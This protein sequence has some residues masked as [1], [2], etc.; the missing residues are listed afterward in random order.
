MRPAAG[1][2]PGCSRGARP[3]HGPSP[4]AAEHPDA[5]PRGEKKGTGRHLS[6]VMELLATFSTGGGGGASHTVALEEAYGG[7]E[8]SS[9]EG[10]GRREQSRAERAH[11]GRQEGKA[12]TK[13]QLIVLKG[14]RCLAKPRRQESSQLV[15]SSPPSL[16]AKHSLGPHRRAQVPTNAEPLE[17]AASKGGRAPSP[18]WQARPSFFLQDSE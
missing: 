16:L 6:Q 13:V 5:T 12:Q 9:A 2:T 14:T 11:D 18:L 7:K 1:R 10:T 8:L 4:P 3:L 17:S 15:Q